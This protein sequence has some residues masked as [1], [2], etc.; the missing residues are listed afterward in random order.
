MGVVWQCIYEKTFK[1]YEKN[2]SSLRSDLGDN[3][4]D[5]DDW[6]CA[7]N[8]V[9]LLKTF[10]DMTVRV[11]SSQ[12][13]T[14]NNFFPE[15]TDLFCTLHDWKNNDDLSIRSMGLNR[16]IK[17]DKYWGD[18]EKMNWLIFLSNVMDPQYK[19]DYL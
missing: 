5:D 3:V 9:K 15:L 8:L 2:E 10:N 7:H 16:K 11:S 17:F 18:P 12:Y 6:K 1:K 19:L 14:S 13:I 4:P